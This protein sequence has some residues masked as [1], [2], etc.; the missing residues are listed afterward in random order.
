MS[1]INIPVLSSIVWKYPKVRQVAALLR[2]SRIKETLIRTFIS[3]GLRRQRR[4]LRHGPGGCPRA[5][6]I[7]RHHQIIAAGTPIP[8]A[9]PPQ[10]P[11]PAITEEAGDETEKGGTEARQ[12]GS[13]IERTKRRRRRGNALLSTNEERNNSQPFDFPLSLSFY[14]RAIQRSS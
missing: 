1:T 14:P 2:C 3:S 6:S 4:P 5:P 9:D 12:G 7:S 13:E 8:S 10:T 11:A